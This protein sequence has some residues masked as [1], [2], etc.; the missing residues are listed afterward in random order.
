MNNHSIGCIG[1][2]FNDLW[3][4]WRTGWNAPVNGSRL[5]IPGQV[6]RLNAWLQVLILTN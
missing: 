6:S 1:L 2:I 4:L 3:L 5:K